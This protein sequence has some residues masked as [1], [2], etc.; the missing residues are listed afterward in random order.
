MVSFK[1]GDGAK[2]KGCVV[3]VVRVD[4]RGRRADVIVLKPFDMEARLFLLVPW[5]DL[6]S[7]SV[8][9]HAACIWHT[10]LG[11]D[12]T[13]EST[14]DLYCSECDPEA[15]RFKFGEPGVI[16]G[17]RKKF[18]FEALGWTEE[19]DQQR[20]CVAWGQAG[21]LWTALRQGFHTAADED[22]E[23]A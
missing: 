22:E 19:D 8:V 6:E 10:C 21:L 12:G 1:V 16:E 11:C 2:Y 5:N 18:S 15:R 14:R 3:E 23:A 20:D 7:L 17:G 9:D 4:R 13:T